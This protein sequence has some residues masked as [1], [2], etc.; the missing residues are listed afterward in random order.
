MNTP[1]A[2]ERDAAAEERMLA[3]VAYMLWPLA[4]P[5]LVD[6]SDIRRSPW[7]K[8]HARQAIMLGLGC[9]SAVF[10][11]FSLPLML[12]LNGTV[13][14]EST[15][16]LYQVSFLFDIVVFGFAV[17]IS[18]RAARRAVRGEEFGLSS[19]FQLGAKKGGP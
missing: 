18:I 14:Y 10:L 11:I 15:I 2:P 8:K 1:Q 9:W 12:I 16:G 19:L 13:G 6:A 3:S 4:I 5:I 17:A 7:L